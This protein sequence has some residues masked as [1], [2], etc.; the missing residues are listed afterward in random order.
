[1]KILKK[2]L[3]INWLYFS[4]QVVELED[5]NF[6]TGKNASGKS[7]F[8]DALQIVLLGEL[9]AR[10]FNKAA[11][12]SS[13]R[14]LDG[15]L[16]ADMD[17]ANPKSRRGKD[18]SSYIAC[19]F[20]DDV[21]ARR[22]VMGV[23]FDC[24]SDGGRREQFF[25]YGGQ[26]PDHCFV[27][28]GQAMD[29]AALRSWLK[30]LPDA[31][32]VMPDS[33]QRYRAEILAKWNVHTDQVFRMLKKAVSFKPIVDIRQFITENIC[34][35]PERPDIEA[36]QQNIRDYKRHEV[37]AQ[38]QEEKL[39]AL[40]EISKCFREMQ[41]AIDRLL[42]QRFITLWA[43]KDIAE[44]RIL[45]LEQEKEQCQEDID[46]EENQKTESEQKTTQST[47][48]KE[49]LIADRA[50]SDVYKE[51]TRLEETR[52][53]LEKDR[54]DIEK[55]LNSTVLE[56]KRETQRLFAISERILDWPL[57]V[58]VEP[59]RAIAAELI[60]I[61][62]PFRQCGVEVF[63]SELEV[64]FR[65]QE[66]VRRF[67]D[68]AR[69][70][71]YALGNR[72]ATLRDEADQ[73][74]A[75]IADLRRGVKDYPKALILLRK[76]LEEKLEADFRRAVPV[77]ILADALEIA[78]GE[79][80]WRGAV[81]GYLN[82]QKFYLLVEPSAYERALVLFD[83][84][85]EE[86]GKGAFGLVDIGKLREK[87]QFT[88]WPDSLATKVK[89]EN[90][91][92]R[93]YVDYL[94][95][96]VVCC[97]HV[98]QLRKHKT[99]ITAD[100][101]LYQGYVARPILKERMQDA[102]I[103]QH[104]IALRL[105]RLEARQV[106]LQQQ[107][108]GLKPMRET[109]SEQDRHEPLF[110]KRF[111]QEEIGE[112]RRQ[113]QRSLEIADEFKK[114]VD[115]LSWL[116][117]T[118][119]AMIDDE[120]KKLGDEIKSLGARRDS[121]LKTIENRQSRI[122]TID[123]E[124]LPEQYR[125]LSSLEDR[126]QEDF[127]P[128]FRDA[129]GIPRYKQEMERL[130]RAEVVQKNFGDS[131]PQSQ[132][133]VEQAQSRLYRARSEYVGRFQPC[134][135]QIERMDNEEYEAESRILEESELPRYKEKIRL[136]RESALDQ[137]QN[138]FLSKL[139][140]SIDQV[141]EQIKSLNRA[142]LRPIGADRYQFIV[143]RNPD[144]ADYYDMI[145]A[146]EL[147]EG[148]GGLLAIPFQQKYGPLIEDLFSRIAVSDDA[149]LNARKQSELQENIARYTDYRTYLRFDLETTDRN[150]S[151]QLLSQTLNTKSG[152]ETQTPF[153]IAVLA[154]FAQLYRV[155]DPSGYGNTMRLV[156]FDEAFN[157]M[158]SDR[159]IES[160]RLL[161]EMKLQAIICTPPDKLPDIMPEANKT[162]LV[163]KD[164]YTM[165]ILP[166]SKELTGSWNSAS[167]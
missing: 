166:Y 14:T 99:A 22:F 9:N 58:G 54:E 147:M 103:G 2:I 48:R 52:G 42:Q 138:D 30:D 159:I 153:Y 55:R 130:K 28:G 152:G 167:S 141:Y 136:A 35:V 131:V 88:P 148:E 8:I 61:C 101:M 84:L 111:V 149:Q 33:N 94:L 29:I 92:A 81:E 66:G 67:L 27:A 155:N 32:V 102:F 158:D 24:R 145:M 163:C 105:V 41:T 19:E 69:Q 4:K 120:I 140:S 121:C 96:R 13:Q 116:D 112:R 15:Y 34:D 68:E 108:D 74:G 37:L 100:G 40:K 157:K 79:E 17:E 49:E 31:R 3:L 86:Y 87:E 45:T 47:R 143:G 10:N 135:F 106:E 107:I 7:T 46:W 85:K 50:Q 75:T 60:S 57:E 117:L 142:L 1:M 154:S 161:R 5:I 126:L 89:A 90:D 18:F 132:R 129:V 38:R 119:L 137:F 44:T 156:V 134:S 51:K 64:F 20:L 91:L 59:L 151:R 71:A 53:A 23:V 12:E 25:L 144:F 36:M 77:V 43:E 72:L 146:P 114:I 109:L 104:A 118:W 16:R 11:N 160:V 162:L 110:T 123:G 21:E 97:A 56:I 26:I 128:R 93:S 95:G 6:L 133:S 82:T 73:N 62:K 98:S 80:Q 83:L 63:A 76:N 124:S 150:G 122:Q 113:Y 139:K 70:I 125:R 39:S 165:Q 78:D 127:E 65:A 164:K 115:Q